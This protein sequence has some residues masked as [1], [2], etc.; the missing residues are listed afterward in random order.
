MGLD[1]PIFTIKKEPKAYGLRNWIE[2]PVAVNL[3]VLLVD[4]LAGSQS[5]LLNAQDLVARAGLQLHDRYFC[6]VDK[7]GKKVEPHPVYLP[8]AKLLTLFSSDDFHL[9]WS[10]YVDKYGKDPSFGKVV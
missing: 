2:G 9:S 8:N 4:D 3:P 6:L 7:R 10:S 5:T 1:I